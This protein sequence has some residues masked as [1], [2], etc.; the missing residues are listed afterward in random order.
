MDFSFTGEVIPER[1]SF[2]CPVSCVFVMVKQ[3]NAAI[4]KTLAKRK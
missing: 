2:G 1:L 3:R 4:L